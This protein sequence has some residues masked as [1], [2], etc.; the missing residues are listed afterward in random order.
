ML[1]G[2]WAF[3][4]LKGKERAIR[5]K[6]REGSCKGKG[7]LVYKMPQIPTLSNL[8]VAKEWRIIFCL[9]KNDVFFPLNNYLGY[10]S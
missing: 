6:E 9:P 2:P 4:Q 3:T 8:K 7:G 5:E 1:A 10:L